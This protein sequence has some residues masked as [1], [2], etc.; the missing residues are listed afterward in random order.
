MKLKIPD[1]EVETDK[2]AENHFLDFLKF[3]LSLVK[4]MRINYFNGLDLSI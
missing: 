1:M 3:Q 2:V 4:K